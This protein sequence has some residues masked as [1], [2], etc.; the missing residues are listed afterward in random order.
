MIH[1]GTW[2]WG[3]KYGKHYPPDVKVA[4]VL[5]KRLRDLRPSEWQKAQGIVPGERMVCLST[6]TW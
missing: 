2:E 5:C 4:R 3:T 1:F 6:S